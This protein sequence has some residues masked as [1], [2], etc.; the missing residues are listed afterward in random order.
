MPSQVFFP[1]TE[2]S[3]HPSRVRLPKRTLPACEP[4]SEAFDPRDDDAP[5]YVA[6]PVKSSEPHWQCRKAD[7][8]LNPGDGRYGRIVELQLVAMADRDN[9][10]A[11]PDIYSELFGSVIADVQKNLELRG[12][13]TR[14]RLLQRQLADAEHRAR[15]AGLRIT[16]LTARREML[17]VETM[18]LAKKLRDIDK[19]LA[20]H[21]VALADAKADKEVLLPLIAKAMPYAEA[22][23][24][25]IFFTVIAA[26]Q[27][28]AS[29]R[30][31]DIVR[32]IVDALSPHLSELAG[33]TMA[34]DL[35]RN[36]KAETV[37]QMKRYL[38]MLPKTELTVT[39]ANEQASA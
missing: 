20:T 2:P 24:E 9:R 28:R 23:V 36:I 15:M 1:R 35:A 30:H 16:E 8:G 5:D 27:N 4:A 17:S 6:P 32:R 13:Y 39:E 26:A 7:V 19:E 11:L 31:S 3:A 18:G 33:L 29:E 21:Q 22:A 38:K 37:A 25:K 34:E 10:L 14:L 12:D